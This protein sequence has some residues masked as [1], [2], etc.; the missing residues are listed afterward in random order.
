MNDRSGIRFPKRISV[1]EKTHLA[2]VGCSVVEKKKTPTTATKENQFLFLLVKKLHHTT[3]VSKDGCLQEKN[4]QQVKFDSL[5]ACEGSWCSD[6]ASAIRS[7]FT[8]KGR[9]LLP[10]RFNLPR[11]DSESSEADCMHSRMGLTLVLCFMPHTHTHTHTGHVS[12]YVQ[13]FCLFICFLF[14]ARKGTMNEEIDFW[15]R[16]AEVGQNSGPEIAR[17]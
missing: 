11:D 8:D 13:G 15:N 12:N 2:P 1:S 7:A 9:V 17:V 4:I 5:S 6:S 3:N 14:R 10:R 16:C